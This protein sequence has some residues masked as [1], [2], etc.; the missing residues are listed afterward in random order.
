MPIHV[1]TQLYA[2]APTDKIGVGILASLPKE[3][4]ELLPSRGMVM[5][6]GTINGLA[7]QIPLEPDGNGSHW[8][9]VD[10]LVGDAAAVTAGEFVTIEIEPTKDWREPIVPA[11]FAEALAN[12]P[13]ANAVWV[14]ITPAA[15]WDWLRWIGSTR[16]AETRKKRIEVGCSKLRSGKRRPCCFDRSVCTLTEA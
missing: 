1:E 6:N 9:R 15:R 13:A 4:S 14:D 10:T 11:D 7:V 2:P 3:A 8:F 5:A 12:D 16:V